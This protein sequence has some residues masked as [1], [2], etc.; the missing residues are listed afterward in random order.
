MIFIWLQTAEKAG[1]KNQGR[2]QNAKRQKG[3]APNTATKHTPMTQ[4]AAETREHNTKPGENARHISRPQNRAQ[5]Y[6]ENREA[7][8][9][10]RKMQG[11]YSD[12]ETEHNHTPKTEK[13]HQMEKRPTAARPQHKT[14]AS[15]VP[16]KYHFIITQDNGPAKTQHP[17][18]TVANQTKPIINDKEPHQQS[19]KTEEPHKIK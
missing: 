12:P 15:T 1:R 8:P 7:T 11:T 16:W 5:P 18:H 14:H 10:P 17:Q 3:Q 13:Q 4:I 19:R 2:E 9:N 6:P